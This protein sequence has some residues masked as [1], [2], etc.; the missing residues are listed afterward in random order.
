V[1]RGVADEEQGHQEAGGRDG[2]AGADEDVAGGDV[3]EDG[4]S[5]AT[6]GDDKS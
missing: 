4:D 6:T 5:S 3:S 2:R 1:R